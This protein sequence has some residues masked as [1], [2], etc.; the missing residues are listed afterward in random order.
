MV[1]SDVESRQDFT[2]WV[3][4]YIPALRRYAGRLV[5]L[6]DLDDVVQESLLR[7]WRRW[8]TYDPRRGEPLP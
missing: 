2:T 4:P 6:A 3:R 5:G 7:A 8:T 1:A